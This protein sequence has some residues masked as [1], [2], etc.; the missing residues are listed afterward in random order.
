M[1]VVG[2]P[3]T[4]IAWHRVLH[5]LETLVEGAEAC[6]AWVPRHAQC[7]RVPLRPPPSP[8]SSETIYRPVA[9]RGHGTCWRG[10]A[11]W[12]RTA[13][14]AGDSIALSRGLDQKTVR[15]SH[16][17]SRVLP[18]R[19]VKR[20]PRCSIRHSQRIHTGPEAVTP[21]VERP[22]GIRRAR[23]PILPRPGRMNSYC[24][25]GAERQ[26][27]CLTKVGSQAL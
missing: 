15:V 27:Q 7:Q 11:H 19:S 4:G 12:P 18:E 5:S 20:I 21:L 10:H 9:L 13:A 23:L 24:P 3:T 25:W 1:D 14:T 22:G 17:E 16:R 2:K 26:L 6:S 8:P